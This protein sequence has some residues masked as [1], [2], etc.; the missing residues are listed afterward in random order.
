MR[1]HEYHMGRLSA[2]IDGLSA[3]IWLTQHDRAVRRDTGSPHATAEH[4]WSHG[5]LSAVCDLFG[6]GAAARLQRAVGHVWQ[7]VRHGKAIESQEDNSATPLVAG[8]SDSRSADA[9]RLAPVGGS[10][11][12][13]AGASVGSGQA[14]WSTRATRQW[15]S[16]RIAGPR[17]NRD[18]IFI[19]R[20]ASEPWPQTL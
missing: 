6:R 2:T 12:L 5:R 15:A 20:F 14:A 17:P 18:P 11:P 9:R 19:L 13:V 7:P 3:T 10:R 1:A 4:I 8:A 16:S